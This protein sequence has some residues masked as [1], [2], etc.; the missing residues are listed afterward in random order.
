MD[1][2]GGTL[3]LQLAT[4]STT[5]DNISHQIGRTLTLT[6]G[7]RAGR[8]ELDWTDTVVKL[9][10]SDGV[11]NSI[12][13][14]LMSGGLETKLLNIFIFDH[15]FEISYFAQGPNTSM[16]KSQIKFCR[17]CSTVRSVECV[18]ESRLC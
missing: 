10:G 6:V 1:T 7:G 8:V 15:I 14:C 17:L 12:D 3:H 18:L 4:L 11:S 16:K 13:S 5:T 9:V 2:N